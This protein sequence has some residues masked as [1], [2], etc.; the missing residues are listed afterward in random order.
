MELPKLTKEPMLH[1]DL[2]PNED[3][4]LRILKAYRED[5]N[6]NWAEDTDGGEV[7]NPLLIYMN[8]NNEERAE[9]LD[10]AIKILEEK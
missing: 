8:K 10:K 7:K 6:C 4:P 3:L 1:V 9:I 2:T 5:C